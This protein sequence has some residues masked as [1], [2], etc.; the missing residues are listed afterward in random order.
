ME[1]PYQVVTFFDKVPDIGDYVHHGDKG[2]FPM[3]TIKRRF[4]TGNESE[5]EMLAKLHSIS[6]KTAPFEIT[7][8]KT[9]QPEHMPVEVIEAEPS[10][11][12]V[13]FHETLLHS[14][15]VSIFPQRE[16]ENYYPHMTVSWRGKRVVNVGDYE[17]TRNKVSKVWV[18]KDTNG[19]SRVL[20]KFDLSEVN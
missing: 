5:Q 15:G 7:L 1:F 13:N 10:K 8:K 11:E 12:L 16:G 2:W 4:N 17:N 9:M 3:V 18:I 19:D 6:K 14:L 20:Q